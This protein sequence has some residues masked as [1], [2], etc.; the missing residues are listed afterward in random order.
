MPVVDA[1]R[2]RPSFVGSQQLKG[3]APSCAPPAAQSNV[4]QIDDPMKTYNPRLFALVFTRR[5]EAGAGHSA[6]KE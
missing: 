3:F 1:H 6:S 2:T 4:L 5:S